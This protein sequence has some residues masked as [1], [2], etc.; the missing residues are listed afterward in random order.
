MNMVTV[1]GNSYDLDSVSSR[2]REHLE[3][4]LLLSTDLAKLLTPVGEL[5]AII[6][7]TKDALA[8]ELAATG[9]DAIKLG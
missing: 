2:A 8:Q 7:A 3:Q 9:G 5:P 1:D 6:Q 4:L